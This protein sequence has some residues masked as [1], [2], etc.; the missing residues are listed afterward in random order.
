VNAVNRGVAAAA[1]AALAACGN[2]TGPGTPAVQTEYVT[3]RRAWLPGERDSLIAR[4][5]RTRQLDLPLAGDLSDYAD[6][7]IP[8]DSAVEIV[9]NPALTPSVAGPFMPS[10]SVRGVRVPGTGWTAAGVDVQIINNSV[11]PRDTLN[12]LGW[13]WWNNADTTQKGYIFIATPNTTVNA[14]TV[15]TTNFDASFA[16]T[17]AGGGEARGRPPGNTYWQANGWTR[18]N[19]ASV[20]SN[21]AFGGTSTVTSGPFLGGTQTTIIMAG[22]IDSVRMDRQLGT[23]TPTTQYAS[24]S[25]G[26]TVGLRLTCVFPT[27]CTTNALR[28]ASLRGRLSR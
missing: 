12:W 20:T 25:T 27:P 18:R 17:G 1:L 28:M 24:L 8:A 14:T 16:K 4:I 6:Q 9:P 13:F 26:F 5:Q 3:V 15:N 7:L 22:V 11:T 23:G 19:T 10:Y 21:F 2:D